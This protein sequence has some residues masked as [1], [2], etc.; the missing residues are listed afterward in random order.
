MD[1]WDLITLTYPKLPT[2]YHFHTPFPTNS[3]IPTETMCFQLW[4]PGYSIE[5]MEIW[6]LNT[7][8]YP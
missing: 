1:I 8:N 2:N 7:L 3:S 5:N 4:K 6:D